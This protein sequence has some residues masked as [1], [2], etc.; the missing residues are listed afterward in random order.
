L[1]GVVDIVLNHTAN[2]SVWIQ[3][4]P[5]ACYSTTNV[6]KLWPAWLL[7]EMLLKMSNEFMQGSVSWCKGAP[8]V[9]TLQDTESIV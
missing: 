5:E 3:K 9:R 1:L 4:H 7:D 8:Y 6:P 2:N